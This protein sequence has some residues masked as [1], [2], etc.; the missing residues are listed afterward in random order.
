[1]TT[2]DE[3]DKQPPPGWEPEPLELPLYVPPPAP[4]SN[5]RRWRDEEDPLEVPP[6]VVVID[7]C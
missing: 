2:F 5:D 7:L 3:S 1:M 6:G 4:S